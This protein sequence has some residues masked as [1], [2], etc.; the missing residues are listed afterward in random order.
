MGEHDDSC[1]PMS[2]EAVKKGT[3]EQHWVHGITCWKVWAQGLGSGCTGILRYGGMYWTPLIVYAIVYGRDS[4]T[5]RPT[6]AKSET[7]CTP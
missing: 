3:G 2:Q 6:A 4:P 5:Q 1:M 7:F